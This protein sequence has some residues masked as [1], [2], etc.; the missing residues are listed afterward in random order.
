M[1]VAASTAT[2]RELPLLE[3]VRLV[4]DLEYDGLEV[5]AEHLW[6]QEVDPARLR[7]EAAARGLM[8]S[9]HGPTR[10]LN[11]TSTNTGI[12]AE[13]WRQYLAALDDAAAM[14][15]AVVVFHPGAVSSAGDDPEAFWAPLAAFFGH[16]AERADAL[17]LR[18]GIENMERR[19]H[20]FVTHPDLVVR[21]L[22]RIS[23]P[24]IAMTVDV[25]HMLYNGDALSLDGLEPFITHVHISGSTRDTVHVP[26][27]DG[28]YDLRPA[29]AGLARFFQGIVAI[30]GYVRGRERETLAENH[31]VVTTWLPSENAGA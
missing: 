26:L 17:G 20:E 7:A 5:W 30:E 3:T 19:R 8:L 29:L 22:T 12:R 14:G 1:K 13:S 27:A 4:A 25:A 21:L 10:D 9:M 24:A 28:I 6:D 2:A 16:V 18:V 23:H 15:A 11:V 31:H